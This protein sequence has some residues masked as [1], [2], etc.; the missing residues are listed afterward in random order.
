ML[1]SVIIE[2]LE[3][4]SDYYKSNFNRYTIIYLLPQA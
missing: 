3:M 1:E 2:Y 4:C